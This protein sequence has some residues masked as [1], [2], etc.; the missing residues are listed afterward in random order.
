[1]HNEPITKTQQT[2]LTTLMTTSV[3]LRSFCCTTIDHAATAS[4]LQLSISP[5]A[6]DCVS[7]RLSVSP[8]TDALPRHMPRLRADGTW[9]W[10]AGGRRLGRGEEGS[11]GGPV[12][13]HDLPAGP[14]RSS[15]GNEVT[16]AAE[17]TGAASGG[18]SVRV[19]S[20]PR[21][22]VMSPPRVTVVSPPRVAVM[23]S[24][25]VSETRVSW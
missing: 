7:C 3:T 4:H 22:T 25:R 2:E 5:P 21:V 8:S 20:P 17:D 14:A 19:V 1:M 10:A 9:A 13:C 12:P 6:R 18:R 16:G 23:S 15:V 11:V 24:P